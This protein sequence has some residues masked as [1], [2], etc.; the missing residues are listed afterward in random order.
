MSQ[1]VVQQTVSFIGIAG[2]LATFVTAIAAIIAA[3]ILVKNSQK[4]TREQLDHNNTLLLEELN[5][6]RDLQRYEFNKNIRID[7]FNTIT[8]SYMALFRQSTTLKGKYHAAKTGNYTIASLEW[9]QDKVNILEAITNF[10][11]IVENN[12]IVNP[13]L[14][15]LIMLILESYSFDINRLPPEYTPIGRDRLLDASYQHE[16]FLTD[17]HVALQEETFGDIFETT[18]PERNPI[19][20]SKLVLNSRNESIEEIKKY[21]HS[22]TAWGRYMHKINTS[23]AKEHSLSNTLNDIKAKAV[24]KAVHD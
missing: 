22:N 14:F 9:H 23:V 5:S 17:F 12:R 4:S 2:P 24:V 3:I 19:D 21:Y 18:I 15:D 8:N 6:N 1:E 20:N 16:P 10:I 11:F 7:L 13:E